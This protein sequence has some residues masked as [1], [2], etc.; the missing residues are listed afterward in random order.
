MNI[1][2]KNA[3]ITGGAIRVGKAISLE[4]AR[5]GADIIVSNKHKN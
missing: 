1:Q 3:L 4:L 2:S 5:A